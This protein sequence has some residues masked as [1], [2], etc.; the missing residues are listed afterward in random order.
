MALRPD[1]VSQHFTAVVNQEIE[2]YWSRSYHPA[3]VCLQRR[4]TRSGHRVLI[5]KS[6]ILIA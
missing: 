3:G 2:H 1:C 6:Y 4:D 5:L